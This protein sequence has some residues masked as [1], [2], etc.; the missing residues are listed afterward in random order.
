MFQSYYLQEVLVKY[1]VGRYS[2][3]EK[4]QIEILPLPLPRRILMAKVPAKLV[5]DSAKLHGP[6]VI[7]FAKDNKELVAAAVPLITPAAQKIKEFKTNNDIKKAKINKDPFRKKRFIE[8]KT[9]D[10]TIQNRLQLVKFKHEIENFISQIN[11]EEE[12]ELAI[13]KPIHSKRIKDWN[14]ILVQIEDQM[15]VM[16][17]QEYL[18][19][20]NNP[21]TYLSVHFEGFE[22][23]LDKY[24]KIIKGNSTEELFNFIHTQTKRDM[25]IIE[26]DFL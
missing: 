23:L 17:Y 12:Q 25:K 13:K 11:K 15:A 14:S 21:T 3:F 19:I 9:Q 24:K 22:R 6:K 20:Y 2:Y 8:Y 10:L 26:K 7:Q 4:F 16:D 18:K 1:R 5:I